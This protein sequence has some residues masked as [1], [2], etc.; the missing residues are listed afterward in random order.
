MLQK[1]SLN[2]SHPTTCGAV[3]AVI[4]SPEYGQ[5]AGAGKVCF[6]QKTYDESS[7]LYCQASL[8]LS[9]S[10]SCLNPYATHILRRSMS[11]GGG[12]VFRRCVEIT[13]LVFVPSL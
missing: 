3:G 8:A 11:D 2:R 9:C 6:R 4:R 1:S 7:H 13:D 10:K 12:Q 5:R